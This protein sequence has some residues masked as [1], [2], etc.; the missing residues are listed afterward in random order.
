[1]NIAIIGSGIGGL[2][3]A[4]RLIKK[5]HSVSIF[6][7]NNTYGGKLGSLK[8]NKFSFDTGPSLLTMPHLIDELFFLHD[9]NPRDY[10][11]YYKK[12]IHC[13]YFW[14][15]GTI[16]TAFSDKNKYVE[17]AHRKFSIEKKTLF[18]Y[19]L[20]S[21]KKYDL[22]NKLFLYRPINKLSTFLNLDTIKA[23]FN[24]KLFQL[25]SSLNKVNKREVSND[26]MVQV[27]NRYATYNGSSPFLTSGIMTIIQHLENH[28]G[29]H[30]CEGGMRQIS[31]AL[32]DLCNKV[33]V[34]FHFN[35][36]VDSIV[37]E[38]EK[39]KGL[40]VNNNFIEFDKVISNVDV[41]LTY[42]KLLNDKTYFSNKKNMSS[43]A[44]IF[45]WGINKEFK[46]LDLHN[47]LFSNDYKQEFKNIFENNNLTDDPTIYINITSKDIKNVSPKGCE[48]WFVMINSPK[49]NGQDWNELKNKLRKNIINKINRN[50]NVNIEDHIVEEK[51]LTP[52]EISINTNSY[53]GS[54]Y[55]ESSNSIF[56]PLKRHQNFSRKIKNL[57]FCGGTVHPGGGIPLCIMSSKIVYDL[58]EKSN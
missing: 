13:K 37:T 51:V 31:K 40:I 14:D 4:I 44:I 12:D 45:F 15:D 19:F 26:Y 28:F 27:L 1:M 33:G 42:E 43:S 50:F 55:G 53:L 7:R 25:F 18:K 35:N 11:N 5:G 46:Q 58:I 56:S 52:K 36:S 49:D 3:S 21:K 30:V 34:K 2:S 48:N 10:F 22:I 20:K 41:N 17:E 6:E 23:L 57:Y 29:T 16:F 38:N 24:I 32:Y 47:I 8:L 9:E 54:L 39:A